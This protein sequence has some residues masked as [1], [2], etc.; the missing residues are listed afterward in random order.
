MSSSSR[1]LKTWLAIAF[2]AGIQ[3][4]NVY[5]QSAG[6]AAPA[7]KAKAP[8]TPANARSE[9]R[10]EAEAL[11]AYP[12]IDVALVRT[13][14]VY[15][16]CAAYFVV[17]NGFEVNFT[18]LVLEYVSYDGRGNIIAKSNFDGRVSPKERA[19]FDANISD[20]GRVSRLEIVGVA[21]YTQIN[22]NYVSEEEQ[23]ILA[24][25]IRSVSRVPGVE[26]AAKGGA[27]DIQ[28]FGNLSLDRALNPIEK[29]INPFGGSRSLVADFRDAGGINKFSEWFGLEVQGY[30]LQFDSQGNV[31]T[32]ALQ[33]PA[34]TPPL[35]IR[36]VLNDLCGFSES[37]WKREDRGNFIS[38]EANNAKCMGLYS[39]ADRSSWMV[40]LQR[41]GMGGAD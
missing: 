2:M 35:E 28:T 5:A 25:H 17:K 31:G 15:D 27:V 1:A 33:I 10:N 7:A 41:K 39:P 13:R 21:S 23:G 11:K 22:G 38:G 24:R 12:K 30:R 14:K 34:D 40:T 29:A 9:R 8:A 19:Y 26:L 18:K 6:K 20:C 3:G 16:I 32:V 4:G 37:D 36:Q